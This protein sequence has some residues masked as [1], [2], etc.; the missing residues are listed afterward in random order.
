MHHEQ[1]WSWASVGAVLQTQRESG[2]V[3]YEY[4][5]PGTFFIVLRSRSPFQSK[6]LD[7]DKKN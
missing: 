3:R 4:V 1:V 7:M 5:L 6:A 2:C